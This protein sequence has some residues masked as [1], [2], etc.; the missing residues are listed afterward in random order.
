MAEIYDTLT[1]DT[2]RNVISKEEA[3]KLINKQSGVKYDPEVVDIFRDI[4]LDRI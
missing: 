2:N 1:D 3:L 4:M